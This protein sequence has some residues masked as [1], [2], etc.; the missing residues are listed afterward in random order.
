VGTGWK[1]AEDLSVN[2]RVKDK[3]ID[4]GKQAVLKI[5]ADPDLLTFVKVSAGREI[6]D[7]GLENPDSHGRFRKSSLA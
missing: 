4:V 1:A 6:S 3:G 5:V 7:G 2:S